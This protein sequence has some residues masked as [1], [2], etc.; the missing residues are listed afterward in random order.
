MESQLRDVRQDNDLLRDLDKE[1]DHFIWQKGSIVEELQEL[2]D[3]AAIREREISRLTSERNSDDC[4]KMILPH[5]ADINQESR[6]L[7]RN[8]FY[9]KYQVALIN[10]AGNPL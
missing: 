8:R 10:S 5:S 1:N 4:L 6:T 2:K 3:N 9:P 7:R